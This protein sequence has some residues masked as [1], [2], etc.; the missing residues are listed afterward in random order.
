MSKD[1][2]AHEIYE[3]QCKQLGCDVD[4]ETWLEFAANDVQRGTHTVREYRHM[5]A[6]MRTHCRVIELLL[7]ECEGS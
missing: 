6:V 1:I 7:R 5:L 2:D 3:Q 4:A